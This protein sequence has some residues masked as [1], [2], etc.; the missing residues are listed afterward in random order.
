MGLRTWRA[1]AQNGLVLCG[2]RLARQRA[3]AELDRGVTRA[4]SGRRFVGGSRRSS[5]TTHLVSAT[6]AE[7]RA[8]KR[9]RA[10][11]STSASVGDERGV[12]RRRWPLRWTSGRMLRRST[13]RA[14]T[15]KVIE[16]QGALFGGLGASALTVRT[17]R[18]TGLPGGWE[19]LPFG[20]AGVW[21]GVASE[22]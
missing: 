15:T 21:G 18:P 7:S 11:G 3:A 19:R 2:Q 9:R 5:P 22:M 16:R 8:R 10:L 12:R 6:R 1:L 17:N 14:V 13:E 20:V 4:G